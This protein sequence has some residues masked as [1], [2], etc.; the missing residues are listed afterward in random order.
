MKIGQGQLHVYTFFMVLNFK[1][2]EIQM[3]LMKHFSFHHERKT[4][5]F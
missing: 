3:R 4:E 5:I 1:G 2:N